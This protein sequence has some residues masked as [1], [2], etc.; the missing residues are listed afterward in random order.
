MMSCVILQSLGPF[1]HNMSS[2]FHEK[3]VLLQNGSNRPLEWGATLD[4]LG[5]ANNARRKAAR[6]RGGSKKLLQA[7]EMPPKICKENMPLK[8]E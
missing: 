8:V 7:L 5:N 6:K 4:I 1:K 3:C 2:R